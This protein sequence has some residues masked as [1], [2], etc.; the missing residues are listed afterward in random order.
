MFLYGRRTV[1]DEDDDIKNQGSS[2][3]DK[4]G[5]GML[6]SVL[7]IPSWR[8]QDLLLRDL[9]M[10]KKPPQ[11]IAD[12][13]GRSVAAVMTRAARL[14]LPRRLSPGRKPGSRHAS[15]PGAPRKTLPRRT[16]RTEE[17]STSDTPSTRICLMCLRPFPSLGRHNRI[18][19]SCRHSAEYSA[20]QSLSENDFPL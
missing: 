15:L 8:E 16:V 11:E 9:W 17:A 7:A 6:P 19:P 3:E 2:L 4:T 13:L 12:A 14:G 18:C 20:A 1:V 10:Q 5:Q